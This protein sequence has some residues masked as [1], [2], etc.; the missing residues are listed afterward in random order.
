MY[1]LKANHNNN[2][3]HL[4]KVKCECEFGLLKHIGITLEQLAYMNFRS[5]GGRLSHYD[6]SRAIVLVLVSLYRYE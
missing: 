4:G 6:V 5:C 1:V 2:N 3:Q